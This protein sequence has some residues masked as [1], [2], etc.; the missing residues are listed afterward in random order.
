MLL[1]EIHGLRGASR[2]MDLDVGLHVLQQRAQGIGNQR[3]IVNQK[4][5]HRYAYVRLTPMPA[6]AANLRK[7]RAGDKLILVQLIG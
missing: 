1:D 5:L 6:A 2:R 3:V 7:R 4:D